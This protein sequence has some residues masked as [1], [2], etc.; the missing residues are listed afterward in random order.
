[1][2]NVIGSFEIG[3]MIDES[4][5]I[6]PPPTKTAKTSILEFLIKIFADFSINY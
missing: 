2:H 1:M 3:V 6:N 4:N 5:P